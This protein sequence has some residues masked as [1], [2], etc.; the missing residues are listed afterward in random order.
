MSDLLSA[1]AQALGTPEAIVKRSAEARAKATGSSVDDILSAWA[2]GA[3][4]PA[5]PAGVPASPPASAPEPTAPAEV[6][7]PAAAPAPARAAVA[8]LEREPVPEPEPEPEEIVEP[9]PLSVRIDRSWKIGAT[10]GVLVGVLIPLVASTWLAPRTGTVGDP[11]AIRPVVETVAGWV[12]IGYALLSAVAGAVVAGIARGITGW[13]G[14]GMKL[15]TP[16][17]RSLVVGTGVGLVGGAL[18][19]SI[20]VGAGTAS[21]TVEGVTVVPVLAGLLLSVLGWTVGGAL[22]GV[23][24]EAL[25]VP[26]GVSSAEGAEIRE[27]GGRLGGAFALPAAALVSAVL[28][29]GLF[30]YLFIA[31]PGW[32]PLLALLVAGSILGFAALTASRPGMRVTAG[33]LL[34]AFLGI[35]VVVAV[36][37]A[38]LVARGPAEEAPAEEPAAAVA[39][40]PA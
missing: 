2:G 4:V 38:V 31:F 8:V 10:A 15:A 25:G 39:V 11:G 9:A 27:V 22:V 30:G 29:V 24:V 37:V 33:Q 1:A 18:V 3:P 6:P 32:A 14:A 5:A 19:G 40:S 36:L 12:V 7:T 21:E 20:I 28:V 13:Y 26:V 34:V 17:R 16:L 35:G 23:V